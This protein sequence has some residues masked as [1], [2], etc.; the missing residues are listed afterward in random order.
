MVRNRYYSTVKKA[1]KQTKKQNKKKK[2]HNLI[3]K[4]NNWIIKSILYKLLV[5]DKSFIPFIPSSD[6]FDT[7]IWIHS[8]DAN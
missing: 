1:K 2:P 3:K 5:R 8:M 4:D 6:R 7:A